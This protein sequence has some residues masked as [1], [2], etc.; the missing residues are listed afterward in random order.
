MILS[1]D[2]IYRMDYGAM[3]R[4]HCD[5]E[6]GVTIACMQ[7][8]VAEASAFG[9]VQVDESNRI[10]GFEEKPSVPSSIPN[11][12]GQALVSMGVYVFCHDL[13]SGVLRED[14]GHETSSH[15]FGKDILPRLIDSEQVFAYRFGGHT[16]RVTMD[17]YWRHVGTVDSY[18]AANMGLLEP[19]PAIDL[20]QKDWPIRTFESQSPPARTVP[21]E[22]GRQAELVNSILGSGT[23]ISG[24]R[25]KHSILSSNVRVEDLAVVEDSILFE[26]V[27]VGLGAHIRNCIVDKSVQIPPGESTGLDIAGDAQQL[28]VSGQGIVVVPKDYRFAR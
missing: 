24:G 11:D 1:G 16:G 25:V 15:D 27:T 17:R 18:Y 7:V 13:L 14:H 10:Q 6:A 9:V 21:G 8:P 19:L 4:F 12:P 3:L 26:G 20:Y 2:H 23:L 28:M 5:T 22:S